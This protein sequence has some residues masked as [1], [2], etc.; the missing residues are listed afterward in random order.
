MPDAPDWNT[1]IFYWVAKLIWHNSFYSSMNLAEQNKAKLDGS[2]IT[3][4]PPQ[5]LKETPVEGKQFSRLSTHYRISQMLMP[6]QIISSDLG[7]PRGSFPL[8]KRERDNWTR[9]SFGLG[10]W[11]CIER[12]L[13][14][15]ITGTSWSDTLCFHNPIPYTQREGITSATWDSSVFCWIHFTT[16]QNVVVAACMLHFTPSLQAQKRVLGDKLKSNVNSVIQGGAR[17]AHCSWSSINQ[18][19][20]GKNPSI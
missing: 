20:T 14:A 6:L 8:S 1:S 11:L 15:Q 9:A 16:H 12:L 10:T 18:T 7:A 13:S 2:F 4:P 17:T 5:V 3:I 19:K